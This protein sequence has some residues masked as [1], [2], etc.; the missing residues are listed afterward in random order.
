MG[1]IRRSSG[2]QHQCGVAVRGAN[3]QMGNKVLGLTLN[4]GFEAIFEEVPHEEKLGLCNSNELR[5]FCLDIES[6]QFDYGP[7][8]EFLEDNVGE[9]V[10]SRAELDEMHF[11]GK[12]KTVALK[13]VRKLAKT[14][15][16][17][18]KGTGNELGEILGYCFLEHVL[19]AP[20]IL[21]KYEQVTAGGAYRAQSEGVHLLSV[22]NNAAP[23]YQLVYGASGIIN[24]IEDAI[25]V[26]FEEIAVV[27]KGERNERQVVNSTVL[28]RAF[29]EATTERL[30]A[31]LLPS[32][33]RIPVDT[34]Y[35]IF[36]GY[37]IGL[38][39][40]N[41]SNTAYRKAVK[42]KMRLDIQMNTQHIVD[43]INELKLSNRSF[44]IYVLP[45]NNAVED[46]KDIMD[47][48]LEG[49]D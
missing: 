22:G 14:G 9:Y 1:E 11:K 25:D 21:S 19:G 47:R 46:K 13:A 16:P 4:D 39:A 5:L 35:G 44:Y 48:L 3:T 30:K 7:L 49:D 20:K 12:D 36:I 2:F 32:K 41:Y 17:G 33:T 24:D 42:D 26:V 27:L 34:A 23:A 29:D 40:E 43:R 45:L 28:G 6:N 31:I 8:V 10:F 15:D 38:A 18:E 37:K